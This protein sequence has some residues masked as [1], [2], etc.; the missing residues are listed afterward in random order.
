[1]AHK[2][3]AVR[4]VVRGH[5]FA[6]KREAKRF[7]DLRFLE[8]AGDIKRLELQPR[9]PLFVPGVIPPEGGLLPDHWTLTKIGHYT[10]DFA[11][12]DVKTGKRV[13]EDVKSSATKTTAYRLRK[14]FVEA[15]YGIEIREV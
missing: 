12:L 10:A 4:T 14:K 1:M 11:Y 9:F 6:S 8:L 2:Y 3:G 13:I 5:A 7:S 15:Q